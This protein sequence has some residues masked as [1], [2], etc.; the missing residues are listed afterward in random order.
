[1]SSDS[2]YWDKPDLAKDLREMADNLFPGI[3]NC[4]RHAVLCSAARRIEWL[5][6]RT[7]PPPDPFPTPGDSHDG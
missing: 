2:V 1:M 6:A 7:S 3:E 5:E 4:L